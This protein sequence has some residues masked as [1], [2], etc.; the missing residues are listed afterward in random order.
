MSKRIGVL[1][2]Y[3]CVL[4]LYRCVLRLYRCVLRTHRCS[5]P[6]RVGLP[7]SIEQEVRHWSAHRKKTP[8]KRQAF[9]RAVCPK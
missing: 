9:Q 1:R 8:G 2:L 7:L 5:F 4:R 6:E 3:R